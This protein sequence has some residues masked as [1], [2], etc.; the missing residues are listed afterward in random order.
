[1]KY[2]KKQLPVNVEF[3]TNSGVIQTLEGPVA[4]AANVALMTGNNDDRWPINFQKFKATYN[5][6]PPTT[7]GENGL[8]LKL[9]VEMDAV[10]MKFDF[11][12]PI[13]GG[14]ATLYGK[15][16]DWLITSSDGSQWVVDDII[17]RKTYTHI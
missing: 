3:A 7:M 11:Q 8:Y 9:P 5:P 14:A 12:V 16:N 1:M 15:K 10:Q 2:I 4:Y 13:H 17:F 6:V